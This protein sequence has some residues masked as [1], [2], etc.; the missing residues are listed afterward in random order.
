MNIIDGIAYA[1]DPKL[2]IKVKSVRPMEGYKLWV[3]FNT[4]ETKVFDFSPLLDAP[5]FIPLKDKDLF[6]S[7]YIDYG[8]PVW[9]DGEI[10][11]APERL[12]A[13]GECWVRDN[14][15]GQPN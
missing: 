13:D 6:D 14:D 7:V 11:I 15:C 3:R 10:D 8:I 12:Y 4:N 5:A 2:V 1:G 9:N